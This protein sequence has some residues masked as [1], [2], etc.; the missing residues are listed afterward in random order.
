MTFLY[1]VEHTFVY[2]AKLI[3]N[4]VESA[5]YFRT[6]SRHVLVGLEPMITVIIY[7]NKHM[8]SVMYGKLS[9]MFRRTSQ[10]AETTVMK[11]ER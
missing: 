8:R 11:W 5:Q 2:P 10:P 6:L 3:S 4:Y 9:E 7:W 1:V